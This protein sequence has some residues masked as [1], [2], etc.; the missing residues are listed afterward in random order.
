MTS[1]WGGGERSDG[2]VYV[3]YDF[4]VAF[5]SEIPVILDHRDWVWAFLRSELKTQELPFIR[6]SSK[7]SIQNNWFR[8]AHAPFFI[9]HWE[10]L[11]RSSGAIVEE[12]VGILGKERANDRVIIVTTNPTHKDV[13]YFSELGVSKILTLSKL[14]VVQEK[15]RREL[16]QYIAKEHPTKKISELPL[17]DIYKRIDLMARKKEAKNIEK[18]EADFQSLDPE[19]CPK[20]SAR[21]K[22]IQ[23]SLMFLRKDYPAAI[24]LWMEAIE[25]NQNFYR[26]YNNLIHCFV[27]MKN[28]K[29]AIN[30]LKKMNLINNNNISRILTL[31]ELHLKIKERAHAQ[32]YF[33][34]AVQKDP[35]CHRAINSLAEILFTDGNLQ[36]SHLCLMKSLLKPQLS[37]KLNARGVR[38]LTKGEVTKALVH[39]QK[40]SFIL[41]EQERS[42][43]LFYNIALCNVKLKKIR[44][45]HMFLMLSYIKS[46]KFEKTKKLLMMLRG[47]QKGSA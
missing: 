17:Q 27:R 16:H 28:H 36:E 24:D 42:H 40:A 9:I 23:A 6:L 44:D 13:V 46:P 25:K 12:L 47:A 7:F 22:D 35:L 18:L 37:T 43:L 41:R 3:C 11:E 26:A 1:G 15:V 4:K 31:G 34:K 20:D 30:L 29:E 5:S 8:F 21:E 32:H 45:A 19:I 33:E 10:N 39:Y 2:A 38:L 14:P